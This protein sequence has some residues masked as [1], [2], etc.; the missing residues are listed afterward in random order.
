MLL[1][2][3]I[4]YEAKFAVVKTMKASDCASLSD[5][6]P[7]E[8]C[9]VVRVEAS[10]ADLK[11]KLLT[12]GIIVGAELQVTS[13]APLGDPITVSTLGYSL[14]LRKSEAAGVSVQLKS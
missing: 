5:V 8:R 3:E 6:H 11:H 14:S 10:S 1:D 9:T 13:I 7:G 4:E 2:S 12:M